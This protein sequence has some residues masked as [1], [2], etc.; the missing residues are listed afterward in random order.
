MLMAYLH[1]FIIQ[2]RVNCSIACIVISFIH[3][4]PKFSSARQKVGRD[5][6]PYPVPPGSQISSE[7]PT[8]GLPYLHCVS[9]IVNAV[10]APNVPKVTSAKCAPHL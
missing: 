3:F 1:G 2:Q 4:D 10:Y 6:C 5:G 9:P 7:Y 8:A